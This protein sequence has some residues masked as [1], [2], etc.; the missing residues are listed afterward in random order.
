MTLV[1]QQT[2]LDLETDLFP[3]LGTE[4][5]SMA[6]PAPAG[7]PQAL[8]GG[9]ARVSVVPVASADRARA[10][11]S[12]LGPALENLLA[13]LPSADAG[14]LQAAGLDPHT[15][16]AV[17]HGSYR[18]VPI[19]RIQIGPGTDLGVALVGNRLVMASPSASLH[20]V[21]DTFRGGPTLHAGPLAD[22]LAA[23]PDDARAVWASDQAAMLR[24]GASMLRALSQPAA[25]ALQSAM[26]GV[27]R[28]AG[29]GG[30]TPPDLGALL[31]A[32][33]LPA[34]ALDTVAAHLGTLRGW[35]RWHDGVL[36]RRWT[37]PID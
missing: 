10:G 8:V 33:E 23:A 2:G 13:R 29:P 30:T 36:V 11:L 12:R 35:S 7:T 17:R 5:T 27:Q 26:V 14:T 3:W 37:L 31:G 16:V 24:A 9:A 1:K 20:S 34:E 4:A 15:M 6:M 21:I 25:F 18:G 19:T 32:T 22:A 28:S